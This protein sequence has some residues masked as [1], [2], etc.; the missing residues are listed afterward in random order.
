M[1]SIPKELIKT[2]WLCNCRN[3]QFQRRLDKKH[4]I[5]KIHQLTT[6]YELKSKDIEI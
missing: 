5:E 2:T 4:A 6:L 3:C 1:T